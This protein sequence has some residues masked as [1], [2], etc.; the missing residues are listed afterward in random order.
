MGAHVHVVNQSYLD[1]LY[2]RRLYCANDNVVFWIEG[3]DVR[4]Q[5]EYKMILEKT[6]ST[7]SSV[8]SNPRKR[9]ALQ[10]SPP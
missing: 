8:T 5:L 6:S 1:C 4:N 3:L 7:S 2:A 10:I 9:Q